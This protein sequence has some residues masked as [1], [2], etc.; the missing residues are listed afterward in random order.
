MTNDKETRIRPHWHVDLKWL[1]GILAVL[2]ISVSLIVGGLSMI[3]RRTT[4]ID[5]TSTTIALLFSPEGLDNESNIEIIR[6]QLTRGVNSIQ[7]FPGLDIQVTE[8]DLEGKTPREIRLHIFRQIAEPL[9]DEGIDGLTR[10]AV[11]EKIAETIEKDASLLS[12]MTASVHKRIFRIAIIMTIVSL[13]LLVPVVWFSK[14]FGRLFSPGTI[15]ILASLPWVV[16][17]FVAGLALPATE[18]LVAPPGGSTLSETV[19][20]I[21]ANTLPDVLASVSRIF[22]LTFWLGV[23]LLI[24]GWAG[25]IIARVRRG[26]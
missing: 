19:S 21:A 4:A 20:Y 14:R 7:P 11:N 25:S 10:L 23:L 16:A 5:I 9:Y 15:L 2:A 6:G 18:S 22:Y 17:L 8:N 3:T 13:L 1:F 24:A 12:F 26:S